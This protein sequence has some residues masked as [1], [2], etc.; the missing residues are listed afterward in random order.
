M[1]DEGRPLSE[2][3]QEAYER[4]RYAYE[5]ESREDLREAIKQILDGEFSF[6]EDKM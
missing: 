3:S 4:L 6:S 1:S 5:R 2:V